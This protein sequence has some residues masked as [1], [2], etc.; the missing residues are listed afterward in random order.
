MG[1]RSFMFRN[2]SDVLFLLL[3][4]QRKNFY[5]MCFFISQYLYIEIVGLSISYEC[6]DSSLV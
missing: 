5:Y 3:F 1:L 2:D 6:E 4:P